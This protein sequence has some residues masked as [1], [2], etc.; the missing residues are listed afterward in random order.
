MYLGR[1]RAT[2][3]DLQEGSRLAQSLRATIGSSQ[4]CRLPHNRGTELT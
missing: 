4:P 1:T 3:L 2:V